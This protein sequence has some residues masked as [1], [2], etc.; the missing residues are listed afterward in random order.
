MST[1][2]QEQEQSQVELVARYNECPW[3]GSTRRMMGELGEE[4]KEQGLISE[5]ME[6]GLVEVGGPIIDPSKASQMLTKSVRMGAFALRDICIGCGR[7][8]TVKIERKP[9]VIDLT[10]PLVPG[11]QPPGG[12]R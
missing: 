7:E 3:C 10:V 11:Q 5:G 12:M 8:I 2:D 4:M 1:G 6:V 9:V